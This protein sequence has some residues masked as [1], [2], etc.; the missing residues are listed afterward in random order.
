M[1]LLAHTC[2]LLLGHTI[3]GFEK[4]TAK[5]LYRK[6]IS[7]IGRVR[8]DSKNIEIILNKKAHLPLLHNAGLI[9]NHTNVP[10]LN[11]SDLSISIGTSL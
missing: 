7:N 3:K 6:F 2:Y 10:W 1:T 5:H 11:N 4:S 9:E 8:L